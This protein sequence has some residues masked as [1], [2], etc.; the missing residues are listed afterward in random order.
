MQELQAVM[1]QRRTSYAD[2]SGFRGAADTVFGAPMLSASRTGT[3]TG[4]GLGSPLAPLSPMPQPTSVVGSTPT[5]S[6]TGRATFTTAPGRVE[7]NPTVFAPVTVQ[8]DDN[9][10]ASCRATRSGYMIDVT[11]T[12]QPVGILLK[13]S[14]TVWASE[15]VYLQS[16]FVVAAS[17]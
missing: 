7:F 5:M 2:I 9:T 13:V 12:T 6:F 10:V 16:V 17:A 3:V 4:N 1:R 14:R 8:I 15:F 11:F